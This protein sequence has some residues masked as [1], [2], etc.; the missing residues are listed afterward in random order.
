MM[1]MMVI[2]MIM[3]MMIRLV[4]KQQINTLG[5][6][7]LFICYST[8]ISKHACSTN[9]RLVV[10]NAGEHHHYHHQQPNRR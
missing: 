6:V 8:S 4:E 10:L 1:M 2:I 7:V 5:H 9:S 3:F